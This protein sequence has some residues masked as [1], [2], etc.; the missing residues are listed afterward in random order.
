MK[1]PWMDYLHL[2]VIYLVL[3]LLRALMIF[4]SRP[5]LRLLSHDR[6]APSVRDAA[7]MTW[8]GLR[9]A[10]GLALAISV[11]ND[12]GEDASG[13]Y[14]IDDL[15]A[16]RIVFFVGGIALLTTVVNATTAP[17]LV[18]K[19]GITAIPHAKR[20]LL[21]FLHRQLV[22][23]SKQMQHPEHV[24]QALEQLLS[25]AEQHMSHGKVDN[26]VKALRNDG[27]RRQKTFLEK[28]TGRFAFLQR[29]QA[30]RQSQ[31][32]MIIDKA[33][34]NQDLIDTFLRAREDF[35]QL[36]RM[37]LRSLGEMPTM[38]SQDQAQELID[39][40]RSTGID[41]GMAKV[42]NHTFLMLIYSHYW[43]QLQAGEL[44]PGTKE[45]A[46]LLTSIQCAQGWRCDL[47]DLRYVAARLEN[48]RVGRLSASERTVKS[49][50]T[51]HT[52]YG[53]ER[54]RIIDS[55]V[56]TMG[57]GAMIVANALYLSV[58]SIFVHPG[59]VA[60]PGT[61]AVEIM[62]SSVFALEMLIKLYY[63]GWLYFS[64]GWYLFEGGMVLTSCLGIALDQSGCVWR[65]SLLFMDLR[66]LR[67]TRF[68]RIVRTWMRHY[69]NAEISEDMARSMTTISALVSFVHAHVSSQRDFVRFFGVDNDSTIGGDSVDN[70]EVARC[71][72]QSQTA[73][74]KALAMAATETQHVIPGLLERVC[75]ER[76][77]KRVA[78]D[79][80]HF[81]L[82]A[83][84]SGVI[85][86]RDA[87]SI[88]HPLHDH[89]QRCESILKDCADGVQS[90]AGSGTLFFSGEMSTGSF[91]SLSAGA[92]AAAEP[93]GP[94][95]QQEAPQEFLVQ[96]KLQADGRTIE[97]SPA[98]QQ[99]LETA[100]AQA[101][102]ASDGGVVQGSLTIS[103][104]DVEAGV[105]SASG[106]PG[107][108]SGDSPRSPSPLADGPA[109][110]PDASNLWAQRGKECMLLG[111]SQDGAAVG[112][113][114]AA[115]GTLAAE[116]V[117]PLDGRG[118]RDAVAP[119]AE[120]GSEEV[121]SEELT[122]RT[123]SV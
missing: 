66:L 70:P 15:T 85:S 4:L 16:D 37:G 3:L 24:T 11:H 71:L 92:S 109:S 29:A 99:A 62:F 36:P 89:M 60:N 35:Q 56:F 59:R 58:L 48:Y 53:T 50:K 52:I 84:N 111:R 122:E 39:G 96:F 54:A 44:R 51:T 73:V 8:G 49:A 2:I 57:V 93:Q 12:R 69:F 83:H 118:H 123:F 119:P 10:V 65:L 19:L 95:A 5:V 103:P 64:K 21:M 121:E 61:F 42:V 68:H 46:I 116:A 100:L 101:A 86:M 77:S 117:A 38:M 115:L 47:T 78:E 32:S 55:V 108:G 112:V 17:W 27:L 88:L 82:E 110:S 1:I 26:T 75:L 74:Y 7:V 41:T 97:S 43:N 107:A 20:T 40:I 72:L 23:R 45:V 9:G 114:F 120:A 76:Q 98:L 79:L 22:S 90:L 63:F 25:D 102:Q 18:N 13:R 31:L 91:D 14:R 67:M 34:D 105:V 104:V 6:K 94:A 81:V 87:E 106:S 33:Q 30:Y 28:V 113:K 80:Q